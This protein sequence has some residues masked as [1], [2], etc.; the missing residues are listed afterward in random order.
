MRCSRPLLVSIDSHLLPWQQVSAYYEIIMSDSSS[1]IVLLDTPTPSSLRRSPRL[2]ASSGPLPDGARPDNG[3]SGARASPGSTT[4]RRSPRIIAGQAA[5]RLSVQPAPHA[6][7]A[8]IVEPA[9]KS[10]KRSSATI[11]ANRK[12]PLPIGFP[13]GPWSDKAIACEAINKYCVGLQAVGKG[14]GAVKGSSREPTRRAGGKCL[15]RCDKNAPPKASGGP[16]RGKAAI[17]TGCKWQLWIEESE[18]GWIPQEFTPHDEEADHNHDLTST[19]AEQL[20]NPKMR[21]IPKYLLEFGG[22]L[23]R[24]GQ[25]PAA[26]HR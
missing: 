19:V 9:A 16:L 25:S 17:G 20:A 15:I 21:E 12:R 23:K 3:S 4:P 24:A 2:L 7:T 6:P 26:I 22:M 11:A 1:P 10:N 5:R 8:P 18:D 13:V 14:H